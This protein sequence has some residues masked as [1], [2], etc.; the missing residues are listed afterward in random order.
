LVYAFHPGTDSFRWSGEGPD[1]N[2]EF[3]ELLHYSQVCYHWATSLPKLR[4][5]FDIYFLF[6]A[7]TGLKLFLNSYLC[8]ILVHAVWCKDK[9]KLPRQPW[10]YRPSYSWN[11]FLL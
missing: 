9:D 7:K 6:P 5:K 10:A 8:D 1:S 3:K 11:R 2:K 4:L